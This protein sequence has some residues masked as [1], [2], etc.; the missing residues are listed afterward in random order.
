MKVYESRC[1]SSTCALILKDNIHR[2]VGVSGSTGTQQRQGW[3]RLTG[4]LAGGDT[5]MASG[6][7]PHW[8]ALARRHQEH[9]PAA[10]PGVKIRSLAGA[11]AEWARYLE[12]DEGSP[13]AFFGQ[14]LTTFAA[15]VADQELA[16]IRRRT[17][18]GLDGPG[19]M[20]RPPGAAQE[21]QTRANGSGPEDAGRGR[22]PAAHRRDLRVL[23]QRRAEGTSEGPSM[24]GKG[25][26]TKSQG[27][28]VHSSDDA[29]GLPHSNLGQQL[30]AL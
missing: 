29:P 7:R 22:Q 19:S 9:L 1:I 16:S 17:R 28:D 5:L 20:G 13:E 23:P 26:Y 27:G 24:T 21:A 2:D 10:G 12:A 15:G 8:A 11:E 6:H 18:D 3:H 4:R 25:F 14:V 30:H